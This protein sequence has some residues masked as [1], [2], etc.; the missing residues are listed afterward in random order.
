M[1]LSSE[2]GHIRVFQSG[3]NQVVSGLRRRAN[4]ELGGFATAVL[5]FSQQ[6]VDPLVHQQTT[7]DAHEPASLAVGES[8]GSAFAPD[9]E[10]GVVAIME[11]KGRCQ[12]GLDGRVYEAANAL[13][14]IDYDIAFGIQLGIVAQM[15]PLASGALAEVFAGRFDALRRRRDDPGDLCCDVFS[16]DRDYFSLYPFARYPAEHEHVVTIV[17]GHGFA[18]AAPRMKVQLHDVAALQFR[19]RRGGLGLRH[20]EYSTTE[21]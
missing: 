1:F 16:S 17:S 11:R 7:I 15:L 2:N 13:H 19:R 6:V 12:R 14:S 3:L 10:T 5:E 8:Q 20:G 18:Q 21:W 9:V 4:G